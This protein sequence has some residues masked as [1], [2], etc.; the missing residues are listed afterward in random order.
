ME[1]DLN[2]NS[3]ELEYWEYPDYHAYIG[4]AYN[5]LGAIAEVNPLT[6]PERKRVDNIRK[7]SLYLISSSLDRLVIQFD[8]EHKE[9]D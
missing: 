3:E 6:E 4:A 7:K 9:N 1:E 5:A 2:L 8:E